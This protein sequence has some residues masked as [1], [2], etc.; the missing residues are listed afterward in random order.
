MTTNPA[1]LLDE[2]MALPHE[3]RLAR[4][5][6]E[7]A[8]EQRLLD[9]C[10][11]VD[12]LIGL[13]IAQA[14]DASEFIVALADE[15]G[16]PRAQAEARGVQ[17]VTLAYAGRFEE[18]LAACDEAIAIAEPAVLLV[19]AARARLASVQPLA[20]LGRYDEALGKGESARGAFLALAE[21]LLA[22]RAEISL[23]AV[24]DMRDDPAQALRHYDRALPALAEDPARLAQLESNRGIALIGMDQFSQAEDA[25]QA[26]VAA[27]NASGL[28]WAAAMAEGN[29]AYLATRQ[30][31]LEQALHHF[32][33][34]R[35]CV[36]A[37]EAP[38]D[39]ARLLAEQ[40]DALAL[41]GMPAEAQ[42]MYERALPHLETHGLALEAAQ[43]RAGLGRV[44]LQRDRLDD[45]EAALSKAASE[46]DRLGQEVARA[47][48]DLI[49]AELAR[50]LGRSDEARSLA[51]DALES[52]ALR[53]SD[54][55]LAHEHLAWRC[56]EAN[57]VAAA[58][59][60]IAAALPVAERLDLAPIRARL[61]H[62]RGLARLRHG[63]A[64]DASRD[65]QAA[66]E[67]IERVRGVLQA[68]RFRTAFLGSH[69]AVYEDA[70]LAALDRAGGAVDNAFALVERAKGRALLD[71]VAGAVDLVETA[72]R[73]GA[74][75]IE[76]ELL[77]ELARVRGALNW[78]YSR[79]GDGAE[80]ATP[81][82]RESWRVTISRLEADFDA[83][84]DRLAAARGV[85]GIYAPPLDLADALAL[86]PAEAALIE[87]FVARDEVVAFVLR[88]GQTTVARRLATLDDLEAHVDRVHFQIGRAVAGAGRESPP[89]RG[90]RQLRDVRRELGD[91][92]DQLIA[93]LARE[94]C[95]AE[96]LII[97]PHGPLHA[98]PF[99]ALWDGE[100]YLIERHEIV[101]APSA[102]MLAHLAADDRSADDAGA[103]V[104]G[105]PDGLAPW[106][107]AEARHVADVLGVTPVLG[108]AATVDRLLSE[109]SAAGIVHLASHGR[110]APDRPMASGLKLA[111]RWL[112]VR[113]IYAMRLR[114]SLMTLSGC[115]TGRAAV[116]NGDELM[117]LVRGCI[118]AGARS[119]LLS[120]WAVND[121]STADLMADF[122]GAYRQGIS[123]AAA[124][125]G[126][127][128]AL[129]ERKPHPASW[130][131][132][133]LGG[134]A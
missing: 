58:E 76:K 132:F 108:P 38:M 40:A 20:R 61:L 111:D 45:A 106:I 88:N 72:E 99:H 15:C 117:G 94:I 73:E 37:D 90:E 78:H 32:E 98:L 4:L 62:L 118:A 65:L 120:L 33:Q 43:A 27:F 91:L 22:A 128:R 30:G 83:V 84:E 96:R 112:T 6:S 113:D 82:D 122:Y 29:L 19:E 9:L 44:L 92:H 69:L 1:T 103:V 109:A 116:R 5:Q 36:E 133:I 77:K 2:L 85:A 17:A 115:E 105:V 7:E 80:L 63:A 23:G 13:E 42:R 50:R 47:R 66:V 25:F 104:V 127:Q 49:R 68:E 59:A 34:A 129:L 71:V 97:V 56:L 100:Q 124:L 89:S 35:R 93:P 57:D 123:P 121:E 21:P 54:A 10:E 14:L 125:R 53:P 31:R 24:Y 41:L 12:R 60:H 107:E 114:A 26:A 102:S 64:D 48:L 3:R 11:E 101:H 51:E 18:A 52:L 16:G 95:G 110:F 46:L 134:H 70:V 119:L 130:A 28:D 126:A 55:A 79:T 131:P 86:V 39:L 74:D 87:F 8:L 75:P 67:Q 81:A